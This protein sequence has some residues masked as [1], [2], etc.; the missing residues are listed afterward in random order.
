MISVKVIE[1][2]YSPLL[3][4]FRFVKMQ[5]DSEAFI[6]LKIL[7]SDNLIGNILK[8]DRQQEKTKRLIRYG[9][10]IKFLLELI[11]VKCFRL[12]RKTKN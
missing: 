2:E 8:I 7:S 10:K 11:F 3:K 1:D 4:G 12:K 9:I 5:A 6:A